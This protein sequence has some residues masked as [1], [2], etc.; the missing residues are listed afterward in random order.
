M[1][2]DE[3]SLILEPFSQIILLVN[4][5]LTRNQGE[6]VI[7]LEQRIGRGIGP[8]SPEVRL[9]RTPLTILNKDQGSF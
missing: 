2:I 3:L 9:R 4:L 7:S 1:N 5:I 8:R 6:E